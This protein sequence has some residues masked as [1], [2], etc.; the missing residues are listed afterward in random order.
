MTV[1]AF[2]EASRQEVH[3]LILRAASD[4]TDE[5][6]VWRPNPDVNNMA[7]LL[8]HLVRIEDITIQ[9]QFR[10]APLIYEAE[11]WADRLGLDPQLRPAGMTPKQVD[12][13]VYR[14]DDFLPYAH[15]V[16]NN[17]TEVLKAMQDGD[18][19]QPVKIRELPDVTTVGALFRTV[20]VGHPWRH[21]G[22]ILYIKQLQGWRYHL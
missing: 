7:Y 2:L 19:E 5:Q 11:G 6:F 22:E 9:T 1:V 3:D 12:A 4:R 18:L 10:K 20:L 21:L 17:T 14:L 16:W 15:R 13:V 8:W